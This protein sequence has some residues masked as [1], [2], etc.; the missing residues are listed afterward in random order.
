MTA[1]FQEEIQDLI[2]IQAGI[3]NIK[4][5]DYSRVLKKRNELANIYFK[6]LKN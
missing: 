6:K 1:N 3:L 5:K 2:P 4:I